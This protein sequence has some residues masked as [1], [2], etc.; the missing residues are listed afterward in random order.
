MLSKIT[1]RFLRLDKH[2]CR[3]I[4][5]LKGINFFPA[6]YLFAKKQWSEKNIWN[7]S[8]EWSGVKWSGVVLSGVEW[9]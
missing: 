1:I 5:K 7:S 2:R 9:C 8:V 4:S 3:I 6:H